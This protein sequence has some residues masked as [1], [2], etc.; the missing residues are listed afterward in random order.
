M[1]PNLKRFLILFSLLIFSALTAYCVNSDIWI[2]DGTYVDFESVMPETITTSGTTMPYVTDLNGNSVLCA[3]HHTES[4][5]IVKKDISANPITFDEYKDYVL[6]FDFQTDD[7]GGFRE[8]M[9]Y[10]GDIA[11]QGSDYAIRIAGKN[12]GVY[13][14]DL[15]GDNIALLELNTPYKFE[16]FI[17]GASRRIYELR[18]NG[19]VQQINISHFNHAFPEVIDNFNIVQKSWNSKGKTYYDN[20]CLRE[21]DKTVTGVFFDIGNKREVKAFEDNSTIKVCASVNSP[22]Q[23]DAVMYLAV[24]SEDTLEYLDVLNLNLL[25]GMNY[26]SKEIT[27]DNHEKT[28]K[29]FLWGEDMLP[30]NT[31]TVLNGNTAL[32]TYKSIVKERLIQSKPEQSV[33]SG[34]LNKMDSNGKFTDITYSSL[35]T[36]FCYEH[37]RRLWDITRALASDEYDF[38]VVSKKDVQSA[39]LKGIEYWIS[40]DTSEFNFNNWYYDYIT[41]PDAMGKV[42]LFFDDTGCSS[43]SI[44]SMLNE[45][46]TTRV[47]S[48][49]NVCKTD[50][51]SN[52]LQMQQNKTYLAL[53]NE[54]TDMLISAFNRINKELRLADNMTELGDSWRKRKWETSVTIEGLPDTK[55]GIQ[56]DYSYF[57]HGPHILSGSYGLTFLSGVTELL[58]E[59]KNLYLFPDDGI[60][61]ITD[62]LLEHYAYIGRGNTLDYSTIGRAISDKGSSVGTENYTKVYDACDY[63]LDLGYPYRQDELL[64]FAASRPDEAGNFSTA[65]TGHKYFDKADYTAHTKDNY[66]FTLKA[67]SARTIASESL[68]YSNLKGRHLGDGVTFIYRT[69]NEYNDIF[70]AYDWNRLPGTTAEVKD[71]DKI[72]SGTHSYESTK[73]QRVGGI[74]FN[75]NGTTAMEL[76]RDTLNAKKAWFMFD[77]AVVCLGTDITS[78]TDNDIYTSVNQCLSK[79]DAIY[80]DGNDVESTFAFGNTQT[81]LSSPRWVLHDGIGYI[82]NS[83]TDIYAENAQKQG[84]RYDISWDG[85]PVKHKTDIVRRNIFSLWFN[86]KADNTNSYEY[87]IVPATTREKLIDYADSNTFKVISNTPTVQAASFENEIQAVFWESGS[88]QFGDVTITVSH[89]CIIAGM[90]EDSKITLDVKALNPDVKSVTVTVQNGMEQIYSQDYEV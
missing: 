57:F 4:E 6:S 15:W 26:P 87:I 10:N 56:S 2:P 9:H 7:V 75:G 84:D 29:V 45:Y 48:I 59:T 3:P 60:K 36:D 41:V 30:L 40:F 17:D 43:E 35:T 42:L 85:S 16:L 37:C 86:H 5:V 14:S 64:S 55:T 52:V 46:I 12:G 53:Y 50:T 22:A 76:Q 70:A 83:K 66:L 81:I 51:G 33:I 1:K 49:D 67:S 79:G 90:I 32:L 13:V 54:D 11:Y 20:L 77:D 62:L 38:T 27:I 63:L 31:A 21:V 69:G 18:I 71:F 24:Y 78:E 44:Q 88:V 65:V 19:H 68:N 73:S 34:Y 23:Q 39:L 47:K 8:I 25:P 80:A 74:S 28:L 89:E 82:F 61:N 58:S 72:E